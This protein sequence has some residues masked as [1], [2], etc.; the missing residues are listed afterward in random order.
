MLGVPETVGFR[1]RQIQHFQNSKMEKIY[2]TVSINR[3]HSIHQ[4]T[5][6]FPSIY[7]PAS[8]NR[9]SSFRQQTVQF[10]SKECAVSGNRSSTFHQQIIQFPSTHLTVSFNRPS[11]SRQQTQISFI[12]GQNAENMLTRAQVRMKRGFHN[13]VKMNF[14]ASY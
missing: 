2:W 6:H 5:V 10:P 11:S 14:R 7:H 4:L 3:L 1:T 12:V 8:V 9:P 13:S